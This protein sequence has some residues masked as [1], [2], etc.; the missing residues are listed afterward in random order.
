[1]GMKLR[2]KYNLSGFDVSSIVSNAK[3]DFKDTVFDSCMRI[4]ANA[5]QNCPVDTGELRANIRTHFTDD[6]LL[7]SVGT[8]VAHG[9]FVEFGTGQR[10]A[11]SG[12]AIPEGVDYQYGSKAGMPAQPFLFPAFEM[13]RPTF[14]SSLRDVGGRIG[15]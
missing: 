8:D 9:P 5:K 3:D 11:A 13:E 14:E 10:G 4:E 2:A 7:G 12:V 6:G 1:M 15:H